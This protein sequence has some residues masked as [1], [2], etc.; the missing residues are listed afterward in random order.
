[1]G[2]FPQER[3]KNTDSNKI[4]FPSESISFN[5]VKLTNTK[6]SAQNAAESA[7][8]AAYCFSAPNQSR[9]FQ[10]SRLFAWYL[11]DM[12]S[13]EISCYRTL[14]YGTAFSTL[15]Q[16]RNGQ[17]DY[18]WR[19]GG[20]YPFLC[21]GCKSP[22]DLSFSWVWNQKSLAVVLSLK[23]SFAAPSAQAWKTNLMKSTFQKAVSL[24][25]ELWYE[26]FSRVALMWAGSVSRIP[27]QPVYK[28][29]W[30]LCSSVSSE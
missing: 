4:V 20:K 12:V 10:Q 3:L 27:E 5:F 22:L 16:S 24:I 18:I 19:V 25:S 26:W 11:L 23:K 14:A 17:P 30:Q 6:L 13:E 8:R 29:Q 21:L 2:S 15:L 28:Q 9:D 7:S 1:M